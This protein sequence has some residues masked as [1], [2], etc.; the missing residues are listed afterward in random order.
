LSNR[1]KSSAAQSKPFPNNQTQLDTIHT[2]KE[3]MPDRKITIQAT[4]APAEARLL[5]GLASLINNPDFAEGDA[6]AGP[7]SAPEVIPT[8]ED[9][10]ATVRPSPA[11]NRQKPPEEDEGLPLA[12]TPATVMTP[13]RVFTTGRLR[14]GKD[15]ILKSLGYSIHGFADPLYALAR[16]F[17]GTDDKSTPGIREF[18]QAVGQWGRGTVTEQ[19]RLTPMRAVFLT[20]MKS[21]ASTGSLPGDMGVD[22][23]KFGHADLW[24]DAL[25]SRASSDPLARIAVSNVRF[26]NEHARLTQGGWTHY[27][28][29][30]SPATWEKRLR[31]SGLTSKSPAVTDESEK[32]AAFLD[33]DVYERLR[34][35]P[36]G[37]KLR[38]IWNDE[39]VAPPSPRLY[40]A[41]D[42]GL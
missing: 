8:A 17:F 4:A 11:V 5:G 6:T 21:M 34:L 10:R 28:V 29:M 18:L 39:E 26:E 23:R 35:K 1:W 24:V 14:V 2:M 3:L 12:A 31:T 41:K 22:W 37:P 7:F 38:V 32:M 40:T 42:L 9:Q 36:A 27:H 15:H 25:L 30:C 16:M 19:Y 33:K 20:M 13:P